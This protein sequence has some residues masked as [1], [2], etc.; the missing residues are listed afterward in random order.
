MSTV[1]PLLLMGVSLSDTL[2]VTDHVLVLRG[3]VSFSRE[4][5]SHMGSIKV[6][7]KIKTKQG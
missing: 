5:L 1:S 3:T 2:I 7:S 6:Q 4:I